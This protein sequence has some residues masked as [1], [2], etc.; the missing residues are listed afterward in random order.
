MQGNVGSLTSKPVSGTA[1]DVGI[2]QPPRR[3]GTPSC[4]ESAAYMKR[5]SMESDVT[6]PHPAQHAVVRR[7][8]LKLLPQ[9]LLLLQDHSG[10]GSAQD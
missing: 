3:T 10:I 9:Q 1:L 2:G 7:Q 5:A 4:L 8:D 6:R